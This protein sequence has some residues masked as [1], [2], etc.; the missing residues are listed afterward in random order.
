VIPCEYDAVVF[1][2]PSGEPS[3]AGARV[4]NESLHAPGL[5]VA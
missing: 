3:A 1:P 5:T 4:P 2:E